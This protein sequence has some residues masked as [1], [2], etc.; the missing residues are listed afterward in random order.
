[1]FHPDRSKEDDVDLEIVVESE[2]ETEA[3]T[4]SLG[5]RRR[6]KGE[7]DSSIKRFMADWTSDSDASGGHDVESKPPARKAKGKRP[8]K[9]AG[10]AGTSK[11]P[12]KKTGAA[13]KRPAPTPAAARPSGPVLRDVPLPINQPTFSMASFAAHLPRVAGYFFASS[14]LQS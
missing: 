6:L 7:S 5:A 12:K 13:S 8:R 4:A 2:S 14:L 10:A 3:R 1:M 9:D 11:A